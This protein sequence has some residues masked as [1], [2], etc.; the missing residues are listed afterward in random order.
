MATE[1]AKKGKSNAVR[2]QQDKMERAGRVARRV[3]AIEDKKVS[4]AS[5][6]DEILDEGLSKRERKL[7]IEK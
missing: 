1:T 4:A 2:I 6:V 5:L 7:G 3:A